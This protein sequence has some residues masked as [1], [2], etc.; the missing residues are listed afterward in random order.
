[1]RL[2]LCQPL[3]ERRHRREFLAERGRYAPAG[4]VIVAVDNA[5]LQR[6]DA[7][8]PIP[9]SYYARLLDALHRSRPRLVGL[10]LQ[11][12]GVSEHPAQDRELLGAFARDGP[13]LVLVSDAGT[14]IPAIA[15]VSNPPGA[16]PGSGGVDTNSDGVLRKLMYVQVR[17][18]DVCDPGRRDDTAAF[19]R[20]S[21]RVTTRR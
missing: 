9:R 10:D 15:G 12:I 11:F 17:L 8:P 6:I 18:E 4:I 21:C 14:G 7:Q 19:R 13:V 20:H 16:V 1:M 2:M 3:A 5:T